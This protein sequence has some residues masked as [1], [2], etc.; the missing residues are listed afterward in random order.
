MRTIR[1]LLTALLISVAVGAT[2]CS[3]PVAPG[4]LGSNNGEL[5]SNN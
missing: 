4:E 5:G 1:L 3:S 2:A